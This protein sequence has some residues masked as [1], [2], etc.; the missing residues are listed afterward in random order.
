MNISDL[1]Y[2]QAAGIEHLVRYLE[3]SSTDHKVYAKAVG[4]DL[5]QLLTA[6]SF[7]PMEGLK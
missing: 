2:D 7:P 3:S 5:R 4:E 1:T 6:L